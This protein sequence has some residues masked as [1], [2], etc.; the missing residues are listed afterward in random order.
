LLICYH[1]WHNMTECEN[2]AC[3][4]DHGIRKNHT[5][6]HRMFRRG[7]FDGKTFMGVYTPD[8]AL[9]ARIKNLDE[10]VCQSTYGN[11]LESYLAAI[12]ALED[13]VQEEEISKV[14][15]NL[16]PNVR[17]MEAL[18]SEPLSDIKIA[19][20][21][22]PAVL[23]AMHAVGDMAQSMLL[24]TSASSEAGVHECTVAVERAVQGVLV[25]K[26]GADTDDFAVQTRLNKW[27]GNVGWQPDR[28]KCS[29]M[30]APTVH[31]H[32]SAIVPHVCYW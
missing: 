22:V 9:Q 16:A 29:S 19:R 28:E 24:N 25:E 2:V 1:G 10:R 4:R 27:L 17:E 12:Q 5:E 14:L 32:A 30:R 31:V 11:A 18:T 21:V 15:L 7:G 3:C 23:V 26:P 8:S 13:W 6:S 20:D